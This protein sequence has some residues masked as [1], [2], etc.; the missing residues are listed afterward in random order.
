MRVLLTFLLFLLL[1]VWGKTAIAAETLDFPPTFYPSK[2][3]DC[4]SSFYRTKSSDCIDAILKQ[5]AGHTGGQANSQGG[6][7][8]PETVGFLAY[9]FES[10]PRESARILA[11]DTSP[12][13]AP[14]IVHALVLAGFV[15]EAETYANAHGLSDVAKTLSGY[16][17][18]VEKLR[19]RGNTP[20]NSTKP[21]ANVADNDILIGA[22]MASGDTGYIVSILENFSSASD[23]MVRDS[24]RLAMVNSKFGP[25]APP[26][27]EK[28]MAKTACEKYECKKDMG[29]F[30]R[31]MT[32]SSAYWAMQSLSK[33]NA[34]IQ[35]TFADFFEHDGRLKGLLALETTAFGNYVITLPLYAAA[36]D[37][38]NFN[39]FLSIYEAFGPAEDAQTALVRNLPVRSAPGTK[40]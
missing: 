9:L 10:D 16:A 12:Q 26:G 40:N 8:N 37:N 14:L 38:A 21:R 2:S 4:M 36:K 1:S 31:L 19:A 3:A 25:K 22:Y 13:I 15:G 34:G 18:F 32:L 27:R 11:L 5:A 17:L 33:Q 28:A 39:K 35:K 6:I 20:L 29:N 30:M 23:D 7:I 24:L